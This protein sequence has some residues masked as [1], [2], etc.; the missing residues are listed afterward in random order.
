MD[1]RILT[2]GTVVRP[3]ENQESRLHVFH[4]RSLESIRQCGPPRRFWIAPF[5]LTPSRSVQLAKIW[6]MKRIPIVR[7]RARLAKLCGADNICFSNHPRGRHFSRVVKA[8]TSSRLRPDEV[9][10]T[11]EA[12]VS[13]QAMAWGEQSNSPAADHNACERGPDVAH[14]SQYLRLRHSCPCCGPWL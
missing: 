1:R 2:N 5:T 13:A 7:G 3:L 8:I 4:D 10:A 12:A 14:A 11:S 6:R 9:A